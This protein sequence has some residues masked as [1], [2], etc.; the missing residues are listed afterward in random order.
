VVSGLQRVR[1]GSSVEKE[2]QKLQNQAQGDPEYARALAAIRYYLHCVIWQCQV[3][4]KKRAAG[5]TNYKT[6][7]NQI[8]HYRKEQEDVCLVT[9]NYDTL[10]EEAVGATPLNI[11]IRTFSDYIASHYRIIKLHGSVDWAHEVVTPLEKIASSQP[12]DIVNELINKVATL[13]F[14]EIYRMVD[15]IPMARFEGKGL[16]PALAIPVET[17]HRYECPD[18]HVHELDECIP[19]VN[20]LLVIGWRGTEENFVQQLAKNLKGT[21][22]GMVVSSGQISAKSLIGRLG[23]SGVRADFSAFSG[24]FSDFIASP[25][26]EEFLK[27]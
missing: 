6:L 22:Q 8:R 20:R 16:F 12:W 18:L 11:E 9:F 26:L 2:L 27:T 3:R 1:S 10:L 17:K 15:G 4:W 23:Q 7:L 5:V 13:E 24:G 25:E 14:S 19:E 21:P